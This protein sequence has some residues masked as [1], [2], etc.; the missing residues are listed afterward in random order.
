VTRFSANGS[1]EANWQ[2]NS[3]WGYGRGA[4]VKDDG[5]ILLFGSRDGYFN[6][7][8]IDSNGAQEQPFEY[9]FGANEFVH[10]SLALPDGKF[11]LIGRAD[12]DL[13]VSRHLPSG[14][15]DT[16]FGTGGRIETPVLSSTDEGYR[17]TLAADGKI[18][19]TGFAS[20]GTDQDI[21]VVRM[22]YDGVLDSSF[23]S[24]GK[25]SVGLGSNDYGYAVATTAD[26]KIIVAGR[27]NNDIAL[28]RLLGDS[29]QS[30]LPAN[31]APVNT[32]PGAQTTQIDTQIA[33]TAYRGNGISI[34]DTDNGGNQMQVTLSVDAG[35]VTLI[36]PDPNG[37]LT[38]SSGDGTEDASMTFTGTMVSVRSCSA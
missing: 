31:Q 30:A 5:D 7:V 34:A 4:I 14:Q 27:S 33:F 15:L 1:V 20:N 18:I 38:Y 35:A 23:N 25:V 37:G 36:N 16:S 24:T 21:V 8:R 29:D 2:Y 13:T 10:S 17:A 28:V 12:N 22:S 3:L 26:G 19:I 32:V 6:V 11:L 9:D